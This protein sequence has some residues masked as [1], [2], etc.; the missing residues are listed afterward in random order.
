MQD[1]Q[2]KTAHN[3]NHMLYDSGA[4]VGEITALTIDD[5]VLARPAHLTL[6][7]GARAASS[8]SER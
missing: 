8:P 4:R 2:A 7:K 5:L 6:G 3:R 1:P